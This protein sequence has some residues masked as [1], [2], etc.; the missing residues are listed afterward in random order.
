MSALESTWSS[1]PVEGSG[2]DSGAE[3][4][5]L[6]EGECEEGSKRQRED[7]THVP[8]LPD[9]VLALSMSCDVPKSDSIA[10]GLSIET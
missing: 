9:R 4:S 3:Y 2:S 10:R 5:R 8:V 1:L 7:V 6:Q